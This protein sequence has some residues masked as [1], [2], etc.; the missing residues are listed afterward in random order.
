VNTKSN[1]L[2]ALV[3][4]ALAATT[5]QPAAAADWSDT[6][7]GWRYGTKFAEPFNNQDIKKNIISFTHASGYA[8]GTNFF[9]VDYLM[10]DKNDPAAPGSSNGAAETYI[11]YRNTLDIGKIAKTSLKMGP[12]RGYGVEL[13]FDVNSKTD[14]GYNSKKRMLVAGPTVMW[15]VPGFLNTGIIYLW[16]SNAPHNDFSGQD[17]PRYHYKSHPALD[18]SWGINLPV[19]LSFE[20]YALYIAS[21]GKDEFGG[22]TA[23]ETHID[24]K[25]M[26]NITAL[27]DPKK[28]TFKVGL[29]YEYWKNKFGNNHNGPAGKGA[30]AKTPMIKAEYHF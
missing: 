9:N 11:V 13:G 21:K 26:Y 28:N 6:S 23:P 20:G 25:L 24:A 12:L 22:A 15:E 10:S 7:I 8:W 19:N 3:A 5:M 29:E 18:V 2:V 27:Y 30:F 14:A 4:G 1:S 17:T 16:E